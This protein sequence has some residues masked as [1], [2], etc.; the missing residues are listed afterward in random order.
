MY[1]REVVLYSRSRSLRCWRAQ[2]LLRKCGYDFV[3]V[4]TTR[5]GEALA[6]L[7]EVVHHKVMAPYVVV[8]HRPVG[9]FG[10]IRALL[11]SGGLERV[12]R[13]EL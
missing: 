1:Q 6:E 4:D 7:S 3:V 10:V 12:V 13:G 11:R 9:D 2:R 5:D 8:D